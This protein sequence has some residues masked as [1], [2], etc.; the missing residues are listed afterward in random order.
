MEQHPQEA[1]SVD[2]LGTTVV[3][4]LANE[5]S[6]ESF[7]MVSTDKAVNPTNIMGA[8]KHWAQT[9]VQLLDRNSKT[10]F[11]TVRSGNVLNS[12]GSVVQIF[13]QQISEGGPVTVTDP[14]IARFFMT[15]SEVIQLILQAAAIGDGGGISL[16][17]MGEQVKIQYLVEEIIRP[18]G[19]IPHENIEIVYTGL[20]AGEKLYEELLLVGEGVLRTPHNSICIAKASNLKVVHFQ[21]QLDA[22]ITMPLGRTRLAFVN[23]LV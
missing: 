10:S 5:F 14:E 7:V 9:N 19:L 3:A 15:I 12:A 2:V 6:A 16:L 22:L 18:S 1:F 23:K 20:R 8:T 4:D 11:V 13:R 17:D 21:K